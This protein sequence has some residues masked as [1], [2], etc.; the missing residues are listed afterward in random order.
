[1]GAK[2][3]GKEATLKTENIAGTDLQSIEPARRA[4]LYKPVVAPGAIAAIGRHRNE[5]PRPCWP[6]TSELPRHQS[7]IPAGGGCWQCKKA[8]EAPISSKWVT[9]GVEERWV[10][11]HKGIRV[12]TSWGVTATYLE[13]G[14]PHDIPDLAAGLAQTSSVNP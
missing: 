12:W 10:G 14:R 8:L 4:R 13:Y 5:L 3:Q 7:L 1:M 2:E 6:Y 11:A 9:E